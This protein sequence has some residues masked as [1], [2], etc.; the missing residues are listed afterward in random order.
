[1]KL[2]LNKIDNGLVYTHYMAFM[3]VKQGVI[4]VHWNSFD[5]G[6]GTFNANNRTSYP[7]N[8][9]LQRPQHISLIVESE[10]I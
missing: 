4:S 10:T 6:N 2:L 1:M 5:W 7:F 3:G 9:T 8:S